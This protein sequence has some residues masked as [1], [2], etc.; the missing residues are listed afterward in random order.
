MSP[1]ADPSQAPLWAIT[2]YF[3]PLG[4]RRRREN[5]RVFRHH[6]RAPLAT[7][8]W[9]PDGRFELGDGDAELMVRVDGGDVMWQKERL[10]NLLLPR[11]P[12]ACRSVAWI[13]CDVVF[14]RADWAEAAQQALEEHRMVQLF[15]EARQLQAV[16]VETLLGTPRWD[17]LPA[18]LIR[19]GLVSAK[20]AHMS[21]SEWG[22]QQT[23]VRLRPNGLSTGFAWAAPR[24]L[25]EQ[26]P[27]ID[28]WVAG[29]GDAAN[30]FAALGAPECIR[31]RHQLN[32]VQAEYYLPIARRLAQAVDGRVGFITGNLYALWHG[33]ME[34]RGYRTRHE[35]MARHGFDPRRFLGRAPSGVWQWTAEATALAAEV[36]AYFESRNED[37]LLPDP[38]PRP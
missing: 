19:L 27:F 22:L 11:L 5:Y 30:V 3:N 35:M 36:R 15:D 2:S 33:S 29:G 8:E 7:I 1:A 18:E 20:P 16:G 10:L 13:D 12:A 14:G 21:M 6:L 17:E 23:V 25:L 37:G 24:W 31:Q 9:S 38:T 4:Y 32:P 26:H 34:Q 28:E